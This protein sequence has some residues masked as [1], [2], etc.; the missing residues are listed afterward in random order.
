MCG[1]FQAPDPEKDPELA[2]I[3]AAAKEKADHSGIAMKTAGKIFPTDTVP[4]LVP[5]EDPETPLAAIPMTWGFPGYFN[6]ANPNA[7]PKPLINAKSETAGVLRTWKESLRSRRCVVPTAGFYEF[8]RAPGK[9]G[10]S[11]AAE[12]YLFTARGEDV[13]FLAGIHKEFEKKPR[14]VEFFSIL[15]MEADG[16]AISEI[17]H[18][19]PVIV[20]KSELDEW[21]NGDLEKL[22]RR[23]KA[24]AL[25]RSRTV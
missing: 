23:E 16:D 13:L 11:R 17:H 1:R 6:A 24:V 22:F 12:K 21:F 25:E 10:A 5:S 2:K 14:P 20:L 4:V 18:R 19:M 15:T 3:I 8:K 7:K 9:K